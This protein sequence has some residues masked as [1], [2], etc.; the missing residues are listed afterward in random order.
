MM[1]FPQPF[2]QQPAFLTNSAKTGVK[3]STRMPNILENVENTWRNVENL[4]GL[5]G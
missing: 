3:L 5:V 1:S 2:K 4:L